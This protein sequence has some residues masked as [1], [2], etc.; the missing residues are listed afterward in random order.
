MHHHAVDSLPGRRALGGQREGQASACYQRVVEERGDE[1]CVA[2]TPR[3]GNI[4]AVLRAG[5]YTHTQP[6][7]LGWILSLNNARRCA[8]FSVMNVGLLSMN[9]TLR[10]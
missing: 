3:A 9:S 8:P 4:A 5:G 7:G 1:G 2:W 10:P 6:L